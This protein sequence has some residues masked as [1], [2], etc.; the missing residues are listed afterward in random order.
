MTFQMKGL[1]GM[2]A[3]MGTAILIAS[4]GYAQVATTLEQAEMAGLSPQLRAEVEARMKQGRQTVYEIL[5]TTLL[6]R[7][8]A[9]H[10]G[11]E[12]VALDFNRGIVVVRTP[13]GRLRTSRFDT[14]TLE[15]KS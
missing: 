14:T 7:I 3:A 12:I 6:N 15:L 13:G 9:R 4:S 1:L 5:T 10:L 2:A 8:K 11:S